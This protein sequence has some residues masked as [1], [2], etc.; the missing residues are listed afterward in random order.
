[1]TI[2]GLSNN[3]YLINNPIHIIMNGF[4]SD[5][6]YLDLTA[7]NTNT[8]KSGSVRIYPINNV[9]KID[10]SHIVKSTFKEPSYPFEDINLNT[11]SLLFS[12]NFESGS[13][14][15]TTINKY[16]IRGGNFQGVYPDC[17]RKKDNYLDNG[18]IPA[19]LISEVVP[20]W[21]AVPAR[22]SSFL[23]TSKIQGDSYTSVAVETEC[24]DEICNPAKFIFLNQYG[25]YSEWQFPRYEVEDKTKHTDIIEK[26][27]I[28]LNGDRFKDIGSKVTT[29]ITV[30]DSVP[31]RFNNLIRNLII[32]PEIYLILDNVEH[33]MILNNSKWSYNNKDKNYKY[34]LSFD[35]LEVLNPSDLC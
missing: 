13:V 8:S 17:S 28:G 22:M 3:Y 16:F 32:S 5:V 4:A 19:L 33:K 27:A 29:T 30:K 10:I 15:N 31:L 18:D 24:F 7:T 1:M 20:C 34:S 14:T 12:I 11:I 23:A 25:T 9:F 2:T 6:D 26:F 35:Y 21:G